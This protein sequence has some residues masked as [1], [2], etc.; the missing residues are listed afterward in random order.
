MPAGYGAALDPIL[1]ALGASGVNLDEAARSAI[2]G[3]VRLLLAWNEAVNLTSIRD[4][5]AIARRH[6]ADSLAGAVVAGSLQHATLLDLG[7]GGGFPGFPLAATLR[8]TRVTLVDS[9]RKKAAFL[10]AV[11]AATGLDRRVAV[12]RARAEE[13]APG[14]WDLVTARAVGSIAELVELGLPLLASGGHLLVWKRGDIEAEIAAGARAARVLGGSPPRFHPHPP[15]LVH[16]AALAGH[17][18][19]IV[20]KLGPSPAGYPRDPAARDRR[21]W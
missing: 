7:S 4:G 8:E 6:V 15:E 18:I 9:V 20:R 19:V 3:H 12:A 2:D 5:E 11:A 10:A 13:L 17:G 1:E 16:T 14:Q 21:P